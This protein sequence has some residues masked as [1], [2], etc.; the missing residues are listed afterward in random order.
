[1]RLEV[2]VSCLMRPPLTV[3]IMP[4][5]TLQRLR[6]IVASWTGISLSRQR[7]LLQRAHKDFYVVSDGDSSQ[8]LGAF[9]AV[10]GCKNL[11]GLEPR[12]E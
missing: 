6:T 3:R 5:C 12:D 10:A 7:L 4:T 2:T 8:S 1:M 9:L 11:Q